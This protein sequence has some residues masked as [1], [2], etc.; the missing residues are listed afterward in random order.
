MIK[1]KA[2][3]DDFTPERI[4]LEVNTREEAIEILNKALGNPVNGF[5]TD[6]CGQRFWIE[7]ETE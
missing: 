4:A 5:Y 6:R 3:V 7:E 2:K 1:I